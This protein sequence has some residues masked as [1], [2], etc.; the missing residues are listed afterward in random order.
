[1]AV[2]EQLEQDYIDSFE[3]CTVFELHLIQHLAV[4]EWRVRRAWAVATA[5]TDRCILDHEAQDDRENGG[6]DGDYRLGLNQKRVE[7]EVA[8]AE[9]AEARFERTQARALAEFHRL[10]KI[11]PPGAQPLQITRPDVSTTGRDPAEYLP[12]PAPEE[13]EPKLSPETLEP[14]PNANEPKPERED[15]LKEE[16]CIILPPICRATNE[17]EHDHFPPELQEKHTNHPNEPSADAKIRP[18]LE[19]YT[20]LPPICRATNEPEDNQS[21]LEPHPKHANH[22]NEPNAGSHTRPPAEPYITLPPICRVENEPE[23]D[24]SPLDLKKKQTNSLL[25]ISDRSGTD[26]GLCSL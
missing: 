6:C 8:A 9:R 12:E 21:P 20:M 3:P 16:P 26:E 2:F 4:A 15:Q 14:A 11:R 1:M 18:P 23:D 7:R 13:N 10:R 24:H 25:P 17:P 5:I 19:P 22:A